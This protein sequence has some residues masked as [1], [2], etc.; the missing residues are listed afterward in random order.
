VKPAEAF[1]SAEMKEFFLPYDAVRNASSP[2][3]TLM[4]FCESTYE[5]AAETGKW[6]RSELEG[7]AYTRAGTQSQRHGVTEKF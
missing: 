7:L 5:A 6:N 4:D 2:E 1:Y 3:E